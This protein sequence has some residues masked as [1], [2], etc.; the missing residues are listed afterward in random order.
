MWLFIEPL[1]MLKR[2]WPP[3]APR[4]LARDQ[5]QVDRVG[6]EVGLQQQALLLALGGEVVGLAVEAALEVVAAC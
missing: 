4:S 3:P 2:M 5:R 6:D 1:A